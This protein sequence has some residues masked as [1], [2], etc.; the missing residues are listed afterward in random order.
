LIRTTKG[1][2]LEARALQGNKGKTRD[3]AVVSVLGS[4]ARHPSASRREKARVLLPESPHTAAAAA[5]ARPYTGDTTAS[6]IRSG[7]FDPR[8]S[9]KMVRLSPSPP[10][11]RSHLDPQNGWPCLNSI[12]FLFLCSFPSRSSRLPRGIPW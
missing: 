10:P 12:F 2:A 9:P 4:R 7:L 1:Y 6:L 5:A 11:L 3:G 8:I